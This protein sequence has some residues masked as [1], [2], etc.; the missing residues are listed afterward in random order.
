MKR[1]EVLLL[2]DE[3]IVGQRLKSGLTKLGCNVETCGDALQALELI[4]DKGFDI[5]IT[6]VM[7][8]DVNGIQVL[9]AA[10]KTG[11]ETRVIIITG[12]ATT[13]LAREAMDKGAFDM[14]AK[15]FT[16]ADLRKVVARAAQD[17]GFTEIS[18]TEH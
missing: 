12:F 2:D 15:P 13:G 11:R 8:P 17:L 6:D 9:E 16:P 14:I 10:Q 4:R 1:P 7:M 18:P 3:P 5:V